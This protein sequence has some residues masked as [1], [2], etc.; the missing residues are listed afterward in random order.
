[1]LVDRERVD[2]CAG[3]SEIV[4]PVTGAPAH[5][6]AVGGSLKACFYFLI[7]FETGSKLEIIKF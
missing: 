6:R 1:M 7:N 4:V 3:S 2:L 5:A